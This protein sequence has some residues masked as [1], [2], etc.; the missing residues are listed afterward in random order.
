METKTIIINCKKGDQEAFRNLVDAYSN[1]AF[2]T[3]FKILNHE[4]EAKDIVQESF[5]TVW[6]KIDSFNPEMNFSNW[7]YRIIVNK[8]YDVL[9]KKKKQRMSYPDEQN[10]DAFGMTDDDETEKN[11]N[12]R[13]FS[14]ILQKLTLNLS[15]KQKIV[16]VLCDLDELSQDEVAEITGLSKTRIKSNLNHARRNI[17]LML[18]K[19]YENEK[20]RKIPESN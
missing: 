2:S 8:C 18:E 17:Q 5:I 6:K 16:F 10:W 20:R 13:E 12:N 7:L 1:F 15:A 19:F 9:R 14:E 4:E 11:I 3:A